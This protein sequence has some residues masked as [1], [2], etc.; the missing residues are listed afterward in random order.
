[1]REQISIIECGGKSNLP[2]FVEICERAR[3]PC[4]VVHGSDLRPDREPR[5]AELKLN[6][7]I[8]RRA[9]AR[10]TTVLDPDFEGVLGFRGRARKPERA[11]RRLAHAH[12][13]QLPEA[14]VAAVRLAL[15]SAHPRKPSYS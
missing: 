4:V 14:L 6:R 15:D 8:R 12:P 2:L 1:D 13:D 9:G 10:R 3:V 7:L 5:A 11:W